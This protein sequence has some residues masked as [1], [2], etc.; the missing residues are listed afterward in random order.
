MLSIFAQLGG[1]RRNGRRVAGAI[2][3]GA[4][5]LLGVVCTALAMLLILVGSWLASRAGP[6]LLK[7]RVQRDVT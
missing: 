7:R 6:G 4:V 1:A 3:Y 5:A 2:A